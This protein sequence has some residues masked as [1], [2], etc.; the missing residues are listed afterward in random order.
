MHTETK[1]DKKK[2]PVAGALGSGSSHLSVIRDDRIQNAII[3]RKEA[4]T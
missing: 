2:D 3:G 1:L 4:L